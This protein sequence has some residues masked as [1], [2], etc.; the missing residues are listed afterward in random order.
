MQ[1]AFIE[2][3]RDQASFGVSF[4]APLIFR[5]AFIRSMFKLA[6]SEGFKEVGTWRTMMNHLSG[7]VSFDA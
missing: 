7:A 5:Q 2:K 4:L 3:R 1:V 6:I